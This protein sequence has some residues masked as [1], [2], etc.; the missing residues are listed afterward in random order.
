MQERAIPRQ[1]GSLNNGAPMVPSST[2]DR[3]GSCDVL[4]IGGGMAGLCA[5]IA[6]RR[7]GALVTLLERAPRDVRGGDARHGRNVRIM[8]AAPTPFSPGR[9]DEDEF[10]TELHRATHG[11]EDTAL[12]RLLVRES[13][14][15]VAWLAGNGV[16]FQEV[17]GGLLPPSRRTV[18]FLG[19]GKALVNALYAAAR[20]LGVHIAYETAAEP[21]HL[22][23]AGIDT[24]VVR[25]ARGR[26]TLRPRAVVLASGGYQANTARLRQTWNEAAER[27]AVRG[28]PWATGEVLLGL[29]DQGAAPVGEPGACHLVAVD[30]RAPPDGGIVTRARAIPEGIVVDDAARRFHDE[31]VDTGQTRYSAWG[32]ALAAHPGQAAHLIL[33]AAG[34]RRAAPPVF[35]PLL[36]GSIGALAAR[37]GLDPAGLQMTVAAF[38]AAI[39]PDSDRT[40]GLDPSKSRR[41]APLMEPPFAAIPLRPGITFTCHGLRV[42]ERA[43]A[44][45]TTGA[46]VPN[47]F[48]AGIVMA[49][50]ILG[51]GYLSGASLTIGGVFGR[52]AGTEAARHAAG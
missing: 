10:V 11:A 2:H 51:T 22:R 30:A 18:F 49:Q 37:I 19:G 35:P 28:A 26:A 6:A 4:V 44:L 25:H 1:P 20:R 42:D 46:A 47:L 43:R 36:A 31:G 13:A 38:N 40:E 9:Y 45:L 39:R 17:A 21:P 8:H 48:A 41:A 23:P 50:N 12:A 3:L 5:A 15:L 33:D 14:T 29:L 24:V 52:I 7:A 27:F 34:L 16:R 32:R